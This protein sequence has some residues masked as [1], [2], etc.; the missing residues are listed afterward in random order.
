MGLGAN[1]GRQGDGRVFMAGVRAAYEGNLVHNITH[2]MDMDFIS[3]G[4]GAFRAST[5]ST[6]AGTAARR[7]EGHDGRRRAPVRQ[8][9]GTARRS[10]AL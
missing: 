4:T 10:A 2:F 3:L 7:L 5:G 1:A 8:H 6:A 9:S